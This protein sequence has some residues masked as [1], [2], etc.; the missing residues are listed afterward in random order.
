[1]IVPASIAA[2]PWGVR[3]AHGMSKRALEFA[4]AAFLVAV[5]A[6]FIA[7]LILE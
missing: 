7:G 5:A 2:A 4:F 1:M 3:V 6:R